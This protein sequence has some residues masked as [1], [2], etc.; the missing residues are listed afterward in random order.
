L[1]LFPSATERP[2]LLMS[3]LKEGKSAADTIQ[4]Q[5]SRDTKIE[6]SDL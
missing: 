3:T 4:M 1:V 6:S 2:D 5:A